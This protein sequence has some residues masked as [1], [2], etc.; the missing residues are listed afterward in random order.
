MA[1]PNASVEIHSDRRTP[2]LL[3]PLIAGAVVVLVIIAAVSFT[4]MDS[5]FASTQRQAGA[6]NDSAATSGQAGGSPDGSEAALAPEEP[7]ELSEAEGRRAFAVLQDDDWTNP[8]YSQKVRGAI[9]DVSDVAVSV[10]VDSESFEWPLASDAQVWRDG[11]PSRPDALKSG[12]QVDVYLQQLG[13]RQ[14][15]WMN[16]VVKIDAQPGQEVSP[17]GD[18]DRIFTGEVTSVDERTITIRNRFSDDAG[19]T[20][21]L[22]APV[23]RGDDVGDLSLIQPGDRVK[24]YAARRGNRSD[25]YTTFVTRIEVTDSGSGNPS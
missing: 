16:A 10:E 13:S 2:T 19:Y 20:V 11:E 23:T 24:L 4:M 8:P 5:E 9:T 6:A 3:L 15:G 21:E 14:D 1:N 17:D 25:G 22:G 12:D 7:S 18:I